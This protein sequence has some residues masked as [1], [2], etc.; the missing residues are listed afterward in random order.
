MTLTEFL[1]ARLEE[2]EASAE[3]M[4]HWQ[5]EPYEQYHAC[6]AA[7]DPEYCGDLEYG[8]ENCDCGLAYNRSRLLAEVAFKRKTV[9]FYLTLRG[10]DGVHKYVATSAICSAVE[11]ILFNMADLYADHPD[12]TAHHKE[13]AS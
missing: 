7:R 5:L 10:I 11:S 13:W 6:P 9:E 1:S 12:F 2:V 8:E 4:R 3:A